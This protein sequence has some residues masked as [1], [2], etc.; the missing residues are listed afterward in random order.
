MLSTGIYTSTTSNA[1]KGQFQII[2]KK[3]RIRS[4]RGSTKELEKHTICSKV[5]KG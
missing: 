2:F 3:G 5:E 1:K 4:F